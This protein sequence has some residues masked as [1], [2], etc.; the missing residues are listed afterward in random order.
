MSFSHLHVHSD[1]SKDGLRPVDQLVATAKQNK[2]SHLALTDH[3]TLANAI[4]FTIAC[5]KQNIKPIIGVEGYVSISGKI[6]HITLLADGDRGFKNLI[7]LQNKAHRSSTSSVRPA[8]EFSDLLAHSENV[9]CLSGCVASPINN[10]EFSDSMD[11]AK[12]L[13]NSFG[14]RF[15]IEVMTVG[16]DPSIWERPMK[17]AQDLGLKLVQTND[18][19]FPRKSD[20]D[21]HQILVKVRSGFSYNS[22]ELWLKSI[23]EMRQRN[24]SLGLDLDEAMS[25][26][27]KIAQ[28][29]RPVTIQQ[30]AKLPLVE[31]A[32]KILEELV[33]NKFYTIVESKTIPSAQI[34]EYQERIVYELGVIKKMEY[35]SYFFI[36]NDIIQFA[37]HHGTRV[38]P[39]RGSGPGSLILYLLEI[40]E[41]DPIKYDLSFERFLNPLR[42]G[43]PDV[44]IDLDSQSRSQ[45]LEYAASRW[46]AIPIATYSRYGHRSLVRDLFSFFKLP[47]DQENKASELGPESYEFKQAIREKPLLGRAYYAMEGQIR[48]KGKHPGGVVITDYVIPLE[49]T[50]S[51]DVVAAWTEG[52]SNELSFAGIVKF[53]LLG[54]S[55]LSVL[56]I[57]EKQYSQKPDDPVDDHPVFE[58][59]RK[60]DCVGIF[61]FSG[62]SGIQDLTRK[63]EPKTFGDIIAITALYRPGALDAGVVEKYPSYRKKPRVIHPRIDPILAETYGT[64]VYQEQVMAIFQVITGGNLGEADLARRVIVKSKRGSK[65]W[66]EKIDDLKIEFF[67]KG[68]KQGFDNSLLDFLWREIQTHSRYSFNRAH[69]VSYSKISWELAW[70]RY[71]H[72]VAFYTALLNVD[73]SETMTYIFSAMLNDVKVQM[74]HVSKSV[75][76]FTHD[77][78]TIYF[79]L[80]VVKYLGHDGAQSIV[81]ARQDKPFESLTDFATRVAKRSCNARVKKGLWALG[82][83]SDIKGDV[84]DLGIKD[85]EPMKWYEAHQEFLGFV[86]PTPKIAKRIIDAKA[87]GIK[88]GIIVNKKKKTSKYGDYFVYRL[89][90]EG[91]FWVRG[92]HEDLQNGQLVFCRTS[93]KT[94]KATKIKVEDYGD[95]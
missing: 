59:F 12:R 90:P 85:Y 50:T 26:A 71:Y 92:H 25:R 74:P 67:T 68:E 54:L 11:L 93:K 73:S 15:F 1:A 3:G 42:V 65:D 6:G 34:E 35:S 20:R 91:S 55:A 29:I 44:D 49:R 72:P 33:M 9:I 63:I 24:S 18:A 7:D 60:S 22:G 45:V 8:F 69:S 37:K 32:N 19:H 79:P 38:G 87:K 28:K 5:Q 86:I 88:S 70:W 94:G 57:L 14:S 56:K 78:D 66:E 89:A 47:R 84:V 64:I 4:S 48:H 39:G 2:Y 83:F 53:D 46:K 27:Y 80:S 43:M 36:L 95:I 61:Q 16:D 40:T 21:I 10:L 82:A 76:E 62:S 51:G 30:K 77:E 52:R 41:I 81:D 75:T 58:I 17:M 23:Q 13:R 31:D